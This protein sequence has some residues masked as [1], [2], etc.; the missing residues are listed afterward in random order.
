MLSTN[1]KSALI[2]T[3][4]FLTVDVNIQRRNSPAL[5]ALFAGTLN[6]EESEFSREISP[7]GGV[8]R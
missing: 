1:K 8:S 5:Q 7:V 4:R 6:G 3:S 2:D